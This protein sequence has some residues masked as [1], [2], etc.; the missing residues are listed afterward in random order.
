[1]RP[2]AEGR[3]VAEE[4]RSVREESWSLREEVAS[5]EAGRPLPVGVTGG[6]ERWL[7]W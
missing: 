2:G 6:D 4:G 5:L 3:S 7:G 1:M